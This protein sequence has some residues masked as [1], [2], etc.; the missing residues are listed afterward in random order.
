[1]KFTKVKE[2]D[3]SVTGVKDQKVYLCVDENNNE[4]YVGEKILDAQQEKT[5]LFDFD[6]TK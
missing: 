5:T 6:F 4:V 3:S 1:M 2:I